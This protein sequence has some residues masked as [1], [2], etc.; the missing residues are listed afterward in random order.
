[1]PGAGSNSA[2]AAHRNSTTSTFQSFA[3]LS[4]RSSGLPRAKISRPSC[5][6][7]SSHAAP[8]WTSWSSRSLSCSSPALACPARRSCVSVGR[9]SRERSRTSQAAIDTHSAL[10]SG[11]MA[12]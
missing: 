9:S 3:S 2:M 11:T 7:A 6:R 8:A 12:P 5:G 10:R 4:P 1:M